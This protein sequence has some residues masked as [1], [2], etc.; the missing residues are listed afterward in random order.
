MSFAVII[1]RLQEVA[2][3][4]KSVILHTPI[5]RNKVITIQPIK[6]NTFLLA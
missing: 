5:E 1:K 3:T 6:E 4:G 2:A